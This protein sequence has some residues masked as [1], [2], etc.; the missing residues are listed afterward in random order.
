MSN[1]QFAIDNATSMQLTYQEITNGSVS[2]NG[3]ITQGTVF[4]T[5]PYT[6]T[7]SINSYLDV[8]TTDVRALCTYIDNNALVNTEVID[9]GSTNTGLNYILEYKGNASTTALNALDLSN[10]GRPGQA[11]TSGQSP[12][13]QL[14]PS[15]LVLTLS[16]NQNNI[17]SGK[18]YFA[19]GDYIQLA[20]TTNERVYQVTADVNASDFYGG[21]GTKYL[22]IPINRAYST[23]YGGT[24]IT[25]ATPNLLVGAN[26]KF[27]VRL[28]N[29]PRY[30]VLSG[31][32]SYS[33]INSSSTGGPYTSGGSYVRFLDN[34]E[35]VEEL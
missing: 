7:T 15:H 25:L 12:P 11:N 32:Q 19:V 34:F 26:V 28:V 20:N 5:R 22:D 24:G 16:T 18:L 14:T 29:K 31:G 6:I 10:Y 35:F 4:G 13:V 17:E 8:E 27:N 30:Q 3:N 2:R 23:N 9:I 33:Q 1:Y 21:V